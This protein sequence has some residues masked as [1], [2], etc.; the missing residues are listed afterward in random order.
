MPRIEPLGDASEGSSLGRIMKRRP[1]IAGAWSKLSD[2]VRF[3][4]LLPTELKEAVRASTAGL[5]GCEFCASVGDGPPKDPDTR[6]SLAIAVAQLIV[7][8]HGSVDEKTFVV[9]RE[10]FSEEEIVELL[11]LICIVCIG[12]QTFGSV[13]G[14]EASDE[15]EAEGYRRSKARRI[16]EIGS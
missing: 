3:T 13:T 10:E 7:E 9:L 5:V 4:G 15:Q 14:V 1:E 11:A 8:D 2:T 6:T 16:S 12:G